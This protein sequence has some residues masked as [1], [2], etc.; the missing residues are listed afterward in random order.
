[1]ARNIVQKGMDYLELMR[2]KNCVMAG[3]SSVIAVFI[4]MSILDYSL[5]EIYSLYDI[6]ILLDIFIMVFLAS[7][8]GNVLNDYYD[9]D[10]DKINRPD[11]PLPSGRV[12][13]T[14][15]VYLAILCFSI[16]L[17]IAFFINPIAGVF[18]FLN[19]F[20]LIWYAKSLKRT[21]LIGN[22]SIAYL[23]GSTFLFGAAFFGWDGIIALLPLAIL[24]F[25]AT[26]SREIVKDIE[27]MKGDA[28]DGAITFPIK[29][30][31]KT[32]SYLAAA[33]GIVAMILS[34]LPYWMDEFG[35]YYLYAL[36][37]VELCFLYTVYVLLREK[38]YS[39]SSKLLKVAMLL[40]LLAFIVGIL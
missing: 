17:L 35:V 24:A 21:I 5:S 13:L 10:I 15:A 16:A 4:A 12:S 20:M 32:A 25:F 22:F 23:T 36:I 30:G 33:L 1:M 6:F 7:G 37:P 3:F 27:D 19:V 18:G 2:Y 39:K 11:R 9:I 8:A 40:A 28:R 38:N 26:A 14:E 29:F 34:P 31:T